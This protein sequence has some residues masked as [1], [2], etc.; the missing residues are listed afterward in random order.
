MDGAKWQISLK[1]FLSQ[2]QIETLLLVVGW[3]AYASGWNDRGDL[4]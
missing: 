1:M 4:R 3:I 2:F